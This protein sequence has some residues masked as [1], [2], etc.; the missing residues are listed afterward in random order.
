MRVGFGLVL[1][2]VVFAGSAC[3][4]NSSSDGGTGGTTGTAGT[5]GS[6][7][8]GGGGGAGQLGLVQ[9]RTTDDCPSQEQ[10]PTAGGCFANRPGGV[11][12]RCDIRML[13]PAGTQCIADPTDVMVCARP[14]TTD[15][16]CNPGMFCNPE[17][18]CQQ[19][20]C[21]ANGTCP[22]PYACRNSLCVRPPCEGDAGTCPAPLVCGAGFCVE[23]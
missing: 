3:S 10:P 16:N 6:A 12:T 2:C 15:A 19:R 5:G 4:S 7:G 17:Q 11:C 22:A 20:T 8:A 13:C 18:F 21:A 14:C 1:A 9:C 23:P